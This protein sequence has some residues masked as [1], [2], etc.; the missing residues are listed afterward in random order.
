VMPNPCFYL[1]VDNYYGN[2]ITG[3]HRAKKNQN[4]HFQVDSY[5]A[6]YDNG[7]FSETELN[8]KLRAN[9]VS[10]IFVTG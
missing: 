5:S 2:G 1:P 8:A 6:F 10:K 9:R 4:A 7:R 3:P